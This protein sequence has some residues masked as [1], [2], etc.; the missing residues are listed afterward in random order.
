MMAM[1]SVNNSAMNKVSFYFEDE[2]LIIAYG[3]PL[4]SMITL[5][6][7]PLHKGWRNRIIWKLDNLQPTSIRHLPFDTNHPHFLK[8]IIC[9]RMLWDCIKSRRP[10]LVDELFTSCG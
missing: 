7:Y 5:I 1:K 10:R 9:T 6:K 8:T 3:N 2:P 4:I